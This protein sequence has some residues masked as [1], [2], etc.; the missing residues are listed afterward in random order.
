M[1]LRETL[2]LDRQLDDELAKLRKKRDSHEIS[3]AE[4]EDRHEYVMDS[5]RMRWEEIMSNHIENYN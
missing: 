5:H 1:L 2:I 4:F 3:E